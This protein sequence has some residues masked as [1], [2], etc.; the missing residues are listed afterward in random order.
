MRTNGM[1]PGAGLL[2]L[3]LTA[4]LVF[5]GCDNTPVDDPS[6]TSDK[7]SAG[8]TSAGAPSDSTTDTTSGTEFVPA[9]VPTVTTTK[10]RATNASQGA[11]ST[12]SIIKATKPDSGALTVKSKAKDGAAKKLTGFKVLT[13]SPKAH[14][15]LEFEMNAPKLAEGASYYE[16]SDIQIT[17]V[18]TSSTGKKIQADGFYYE[19]YS[20][21]ETDQLNKRTDKA[22]CFRIRISPKEEGTWDFTVTLKIGG[23]KVDSLS[24]YVNVAYNKEG[25][26]ILSVEPVRKQN[27]KRANGE[28]ISMVGEN[29]AWQI[30]VTQSTRSYQFIGNEMKYCA[31]YGA[32]YARVWDGFGLTLRKSVGPKLTINQAGA[33]QWDRLYDLADDLDMYISMV[34]FTHGETSA[35]ESLPEAGFDGSVWCVKRD[36]FLAE[37]KDFFTD[38]KTRKA[39][40]QYLRYVVARWGYNEH[41]LTWELFN[42]GDIS[43]AGALGMVDEIRNWIAEMAEYL[44]GVD[45]Y[46]HMVSFSVAGQGSTLATYNVLD[47]IY[48][49][50]YNYNKISELVDFQKTNWQT[51]K[52]PVLYGEVGI[53]GA[54]GA[55]A[56]GSITPELINFHQQNW[57]GVMGGGAGACI[58]WFW[59][60]LKKVEG[61]WDYKVVAEMSQQIPWNDTTMFMV[62]TKSAN[63]NTDQVEALGYRGKDYAYIWFY[64]NQFN[65]ITKQETTFPNVTAQVKLSNGTY[66]VRWINTW[67][68]ISIKKEVVT[69][70]NGVLPLKLPKWSKDIAVAITTD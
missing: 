25:S 31:E 21:L 9:V 70:K 69:V 54:M 41:V 19:E 26:K 14:E 8:T 48:I 64:D 1:K 52:K 18:A 67:T 17:M 56:G 20:F 43:D 35:R 3:L 37:A 38:E 12:T 49:H 32:N 50:R 30:P 42:E 5:S 7:S 40:K 36:G 68:G 24:G 27:F 16:E 28:V 61:Y 13:A 11:Q 57:A 59:D 63:L 58:N 29:I 46:T 60:E 15:L 47:F 51:Y 66:H 22:P 33:A 53:N 55:L 4:T 10:K 23:K 45:P 62:N 2:A 39:V 34:F 44:R 65:T 6:K